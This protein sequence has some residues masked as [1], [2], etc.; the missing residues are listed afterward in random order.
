MNCD[1]TLDLKAKVVGSGVIV[2]ECKGSLVDEICRK[3]M[4][5]S[6]L[7]AETLAFKDG[8]VLVIKKK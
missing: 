4:A 8:I 7:M 5:S 6:A 1:G 2:R 3:R